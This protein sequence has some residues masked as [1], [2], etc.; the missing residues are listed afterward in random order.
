MSGRHHRLDY[1]QMIRKESSQLSDVARIQ[2]RVT[3]LGVALY[4]SAIVFILSANVRFFGKFSSE[5][6]G[7]CKRKSSASKSARERYLQ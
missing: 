4:L 7:R 2:A 5:K 1:V 3:W 6:R